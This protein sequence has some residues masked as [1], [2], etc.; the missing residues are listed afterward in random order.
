M[1]LDEWAS[2]DMKTLN[3]SRG[4]SFWGHRGAVETR[5]QAQP[6][7]AMSLSV[8]NLPPC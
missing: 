6:S 8:P 2:A 5:T 7:C 3:T 4:T 1:T